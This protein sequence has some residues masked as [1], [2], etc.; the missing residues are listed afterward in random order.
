MQGALFGSAPVDGGL[1]CAFGEPWM[2]PH[3]LC[4][5]D[6]ERG[7]VEFTRLVAAGVYDA[8]GYTPNERKAQQKRKHAEA[9]S[10]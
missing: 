7:C 10:K 8:Q 2:G 9:V 1:V 6:T 5:A 3:P 4:D